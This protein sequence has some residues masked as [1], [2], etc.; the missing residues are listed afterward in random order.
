MLNKIEQVVNNVKSV[1]NLIGD[2]KVHSESGFTVHYIID[3]GL[4]QSWVSSIQNTLLNR[5]KQTMVI[6]PIVE[7]NNYLE[8]KYGEKTYNFSIVDC[9]DGDDRAIVVVGAVI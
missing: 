8:F 7:R 3:E 9:F 6:E 1:C 5:I 4:V 2:V